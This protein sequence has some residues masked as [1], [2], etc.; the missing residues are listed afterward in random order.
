MYT[1][2]EFFAV[3][4]QA[5]PLLAS[6]ARYGVTPDDLHRCLLAYTDNFAAEGARRR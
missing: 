4:R 5:E 6:L 2:A 3:Q 1:A